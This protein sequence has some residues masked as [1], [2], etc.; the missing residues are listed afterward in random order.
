[1]KTIQPTYETIKTLLKEN[2]A[3][4]IRIGKNK[5]KIQNCYKDKKGTTFALSSVGEHRL[6]LYSELYIE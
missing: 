3:I 2:K 4:Y 6:D 5:A 1:M